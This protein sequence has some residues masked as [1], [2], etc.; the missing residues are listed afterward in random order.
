MDDHSRKRKLTEEV[1]EV[2]MEPYMYMRWA[3]IRGICSSQAKHG[4]LRKNGTGIGDVDKV[5]GSKTTSGGGKKIFL[6]PYTRKRKRTFRD[7]ECWA[8]L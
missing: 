8:P 5:K 2:N 1:R 6:L 4:S 7:G 3:L